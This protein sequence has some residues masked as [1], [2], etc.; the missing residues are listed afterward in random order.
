M[1]T[2]ADK[3][4]A[5]ITIRSNLGYALFAV[6]IVFYGLGVAVAAAFPNAIAAG[7]QLV[8][9]GLLLVILSVLILVVCWW[10]INGIKPDKR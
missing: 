2:K 5:I 3:E 6:G 7:G 10:Q 9:D 8:T 1:A 4:I